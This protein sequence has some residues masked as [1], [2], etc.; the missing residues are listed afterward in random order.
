M[1]RSTRPTR[2]CTSSIS[3]PGRIGR[4]F[5]TEYDPEEKLFFGYVVGPS[6]E[7]GYFCSDELASVEGPFGLRI[8]RDL[9]FDPV[10]LSRVRAEWA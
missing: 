3:P 5:A 1:P 8:E 6:P 4:G 2:S 7:F 9:Y 10:P